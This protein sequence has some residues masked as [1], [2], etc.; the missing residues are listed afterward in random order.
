MSQQV[1]HKYTPLFLCLFVIIG[2]TAFYLYNYPVVHIGLSCLRFVC[3]IMVWAVLLRINAIHFPKWTLLYFIYFVYQEIIAIY[4]HANVITPISNAINIFTLIL[5][6][7]YFSHS[8]IQRTLHIFACVFAFIVCLNFM[9]LLIAPNGIFNGKF[10]IGGNYNQMGILLLCA[11]IT[12]AVNYQT[13]H[14][15]LVLLL[16]VIILSIS[17]TFLVGSMTATVGLTIFALSLLLRTKR[18]QRIAL[19]VFLIFIVLFLAV[20]VFLQGDI[21]E[22]P[23]VVYFIENVLHKDLTF[24]AR[25]AVWD[26]VRYFIEQSWLIGYGTQNSTWFEDNFGVTTAHNIFYQQMIEGGAIQLGILCAI[27]LGIIS[28]CIKNRHFQQENLLFG[29]CVAFLMMGFESYPI[30]YTLYLFMLVYY[31]PTIYAKQSPI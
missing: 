21:S 10:L 24:T 17:S 1:V 9:T 8:D 12:C 20:A 30:F 14:K 13:S 18:V 29:I 5:L 19:F 2:Q 15:H 26:N 7:N 4:L 23:I 22:Y 3:C 6:F 31:V 25:V 28:N 16:C 27:I 11:M